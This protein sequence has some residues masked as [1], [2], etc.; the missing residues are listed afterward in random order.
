MIARVNSDLYVPPVVSALVK[1][2]CRKLMVSY[3]IYYIFISQILPSAKEKPHRIL[4]CK[5][6][7]LVKT[8]WKGFVK[9]VGRRLVV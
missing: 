6:I 7:R 1:R 8:Q 4:S 5:S 2:L 9:R 3:I